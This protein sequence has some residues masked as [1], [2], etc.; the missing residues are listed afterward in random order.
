[1]PDMLA[2]TVMMSLRYIL[3][4]SATFSPILKATVGLVGPNNQSCFDKASVNSLI[5]LVRTVWAF[6]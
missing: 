6:L 3:S 1:L 5:S 4:G 2:A